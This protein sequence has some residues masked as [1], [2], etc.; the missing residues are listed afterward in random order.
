[1]GHKTQAVVGETAG[2]ELVDGFF[3]AVTVEED[4]NDFPQ[5]WLVLSRL[6]G[7]GHGFLLLWQ[8]VK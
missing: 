6:C 5:Y 4:T 7:I 8:K 3:Q 2:L 1:V